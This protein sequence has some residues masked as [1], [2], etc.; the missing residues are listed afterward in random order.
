MPYE[1]T[2]FILI[3]K[4]FKS[5]KTQT[6]KKKKKTKKKK[7]QQ[8]QQRSGGRDE[9]EIVWSNPEEE[10]ID[11]VCESYKSFHLRQVTFC[12]VMLRGK[13]T[14]SALLQTVSVNAMYVTLSYLSSSGH[15][16]LSLACGIPTNKYMRVECETLLIILVS[17]K[18]IPC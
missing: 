8:Q 2:Y 17:L 14:V 10:L 7:R 9:P 15:P 1:F 4:L 6:N 5:E 3:C 11:Q 12:K 18:L 16:Y 13:F